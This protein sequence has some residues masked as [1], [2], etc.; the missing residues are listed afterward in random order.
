MGLTFFVSIFVS[1]RIENQSINAVE[2]KTEQLREQVCL[3]IGYSFINKRNCIIS[4][5][6]TICRMVMRVHDIDVGVRLQR[7][8]YW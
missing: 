6:K 4:K 8:I 1:Y 7:G 3:A 5:I 2:T